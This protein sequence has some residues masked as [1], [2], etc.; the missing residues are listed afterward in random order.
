MGARKD[1]TSQ[2]KIS[3]KKSKEQEKSVVSKEIIKYAWDILL[4]YC[5]HLNLLWFISFL[6][7]SET[8]KSKIIKIRRY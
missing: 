7:L 8:W 6:H 3:S 2:I 5:K 1:L 4:K